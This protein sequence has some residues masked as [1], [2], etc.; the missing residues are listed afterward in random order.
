MNAKASRLYKK[1]RLL[2]LNSKNLKLSYM[3]DFQLEYKLDIIY[4]YNENSN[5]KI[6]FEKYFLIYF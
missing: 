4:S 6:E 1:F 3:D 2:S 5:L